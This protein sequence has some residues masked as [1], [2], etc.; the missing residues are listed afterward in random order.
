MKTAANIE[1]SI[2]GD[3]WEKRE[4][5]KHFV[6]SLS[7]QLCAVPNIWHHEQTSNHATATPPPGANMPKVHLQP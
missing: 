5:K 4:K 2:L 3:P 7:Y 6:P 1:V